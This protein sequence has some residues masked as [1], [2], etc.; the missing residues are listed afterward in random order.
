MST[1]PVYGPTFAEMRDPTRLPAAF[2]ARARQALREA[3]LDP[4]NLFNIHWKDDEGRVRALVL[5]EALVNVDAT[6]LVLTGDGFPT[7]SHKVGAAYSCLIEKQ[8]DGDITPGEHV[9]IFP[10]TGN[11]GIGG[12]WVGPRMGYRSLVVL[13]EDMSRERFEKI[14][15]Y[16]AEVI[17][18]PGCE[19]NVK[20]I[21]D[22]V[23]ELKRDPRYRSVNQFEEL[24]NYRFHY[25]VT[26]EAV[27]EAART[28]APGKRVAAFVSA[29]GSSGTIGA[30]DRL[31]QV[32]PSTLAVGLEPIQC[33]TLYDVGFGGHRIEGI[34][35]K[36]VTWIHNVLN[37]DYLMC[38]DD[39][40]CLEALSVV[41]DGGE[42]LTGIGLS[43]AEAAALRGRFGVSGMCNLIGAIKTARVLGLGRD[44]VV[45]TVATDGFD[46]YPSVLEKLAAQT[47]PLDRDLFHRRL[48]HLHLVGGDWVQEGTRETRRRWHNQKY[49]TWV[50]Q[51][52]KDVDELRELA[53]PGFW[54][55][56]QEKIA[57]ID[58]AL[59]EARGPLS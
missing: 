17:A 7:G 29:M 26:A 25:G 45:V 34:G 42:W 28:L 47:K 54:L 30:A 35:D 21:Y 15:G 13:P 10:S 3:P 55:R 50:E 23:N 9:P 56:H 16:G 31:K 44:D 38:I 24:G 27:L 22:K 6:I 5:P 4:I 46:R 40:A 41:Q 39:Q 58:A 33:P 19:S 36:H 18:T 2:H 8:L 32:D 12:A 51:Q 59:S 43:A 53:D 37:M 52:G 49:F 14:R 1:A 11:F 57:A 48:G 20:E